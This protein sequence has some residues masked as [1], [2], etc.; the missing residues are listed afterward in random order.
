MPMHREI[1][2][3]LRGVQPRDVESIGEVL[4]KCGISTIEV[5][6]NSPDPFESISKL[7]RRF[8]TVAQIGAGT[9]LDQA[10]VRRVADVGG[11]IIGNAPQPA[12]K[13]IAR[14]Q[15]RFPDICIDFALYDWTTAKSMISNRLA[16]V[17]LITD[18]PKHENWE[19]IHIESARYVIYCRCDHPFAKRTKISLSELEQ[20]TVILPEKGSLTR[21]LLDQACDRYAISLARTATM[22]T[23]PLM[24]EAVLQGIGVALFLQN[25]SLIK[26]QLC[27]IN[28]KEMPEVRNTSLIATKDRARLKLVLQFINAAIE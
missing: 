6:L 15:S 24:C 18:A 28:I 26:D 17:G 25:S 3:I 13:I 11:Q 19:K 2:A 14:F 5:P 21:H 12:L 22:T 23:F 10:D 4:I 16:D 8:G 7:A 1:I 27:E 9:V 20:E